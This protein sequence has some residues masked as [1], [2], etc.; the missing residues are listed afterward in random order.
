M[1]RMVRMT[2]SIRMAFVIMMVFGVGDTGDG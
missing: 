1:L 2:T